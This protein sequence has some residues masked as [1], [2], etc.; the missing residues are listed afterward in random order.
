MGIEASEIF[1]AA[2]SN[3]P[4]RASKTRKTSG[5]LLT[6]TASLPVGLCIFTSSAMNLT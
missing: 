1:G 3:V 5:A 6:G 4:W 2:P